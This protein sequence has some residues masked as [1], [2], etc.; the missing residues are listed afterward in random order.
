MIFGT[1]KIEAAI[2]D[3]DGTMF[4]T[5]T[6]R[7]E[8][9]KNA[10]QLIY[11]EAASDDLLLNS[12]GVNSETAENFAKAVY[13]DNYPYKEIRQKAD[14][15][16]VQY[17]REHGVPV[18]KGLYD[19][20]ERLKKNDVLLALATSS[21]KEIATEYLRRANVIHFF[22]T[23]VCG[24]EIEN[25]KPDPE[26]F[27][28]AAAELNCE[29]E[30][31]LIL[32]DSENGITAAAKS[33]GIPL[34]IKDIKEPPDNIIAM[35]HKY[36]LSMQDLLD[37]LILYTKTISAPLLNEHFPQTVGHAVVGIH[38]FGAIGGG[39]LAQIF[40]H[41]DGYTRPAKIIGATRNS[42]V[43]EL[44]NSFGKYNIGY[45][46]VGYYQTI[47]NIDI[48]DI[49]DE[50]EMLNMYKES[51]I[52]GLSL[53]EAAIKSQAELIAKGLINRYNNGGRDLTILIILNK[54]NG[55]KFVKKNIDNALVKLVGNVETNLILS[56][57]HFCDTVVNRMVNTISEE[58]VLKQI[59]KEL[60]DMETLIKNEALNIDAIYSL[61]DTFKRF[62]KMKLLKEKESPLVKNIT[63]ILSK[64]SHYVQ[65]VS[66]ISITFFNS[67][68]DMVLY[69]SNNSTFL[70]RLRQVEIVDDISIIQNI[71]NKLSNGT[72]AI[73]AWYAGLL[74]YK[75]IGQGM[76]DKRVLTLVNKIMQQEIKPSLTKN[77]P[78][79]TQYINIFINN[80]IKRCRMSFK[81]ACFRVGRDPLRKLQANER[82]I[83]TIKLA[84][85]YGI[86]TPYL[87]FGAACGILYS[88]KQVNPN[89]KESIFIKEL[90]ETNNSINEVLT[91]N[92]KYS[93]NVYLGMDKEKDIGIINAIKEKFNMLKSKMDTEDDKLIK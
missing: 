70:K 50:E 1:K 52:I 13:G 43:K 53:P 73:I 63:D 55:G 49:Q 64:I 27:L 65:L 18:K 87:E 37:D 85:E 86:E 29:P 45:E 33:G 10:S 69:A 76:G 54:I 74:G 83:S 89:D 79:Y 72:H 67:E 32:E 4:D 39:Y 90:Y 61:N 19:V 34:L 22:N 40:S 5:E 88:I 24:D 92:G 47:R 68:P 9:I 56:K 35:A 84:K 2:F 23:I 57:T 21:R 11:G 6:L 26:I 12:L 42:V 7:I 71:K 17:V 80:F 62:S 91:F 31:C 3:M 14:E 30:N 48:I 15:M 44:I 58:K 75:S 51:D 25:G 66:E 20:L 78:Q 81:D 38:G 8:M 46:S 16:E 36:Y 60:C 59:H 77:N 41:W 93:E 28:K 82:I